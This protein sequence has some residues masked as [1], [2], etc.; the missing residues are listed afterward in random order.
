MNGLELDFYGATVRVVSDHAGVLESLR[1]DFE[2]FLAAGPAGG[3]SPVRLALSLGP[4]RAAGPTPSFLPTFRTREYAVYDKGKTRFIH[5]ADAALAVYDFAK[6]SGQIYCEDP[7]RLHELG[8]LA[9]LSRIGEELDLR[10]LH[11][12]HALGF[13]FAGRGGILLLPSGGGKSVLAL[14][15][16]RSTELGLLSDDTPLLSR[17]GRLAAFPLRLAFG[18]SEDLSDIPGRFIRPFRRRRYGLKRLA[19]GAFF[20]GRVRS[21]LPAAWLLI[22]ERREGSKPLIEP[23]GRLSAARALALN[24]VVGWGVAQMAEYL[25]RPSLDDIWSLSVIAASR[26]RS[27]WRLLTSVRPQRF[28]M[29]SDRAANAAALASFLRSQTG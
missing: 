17:E 15:L 12:V 8:Y 20:R 25:L 10:G 27:G 24:L 13:E 22:G 2:Y 21:G 16:L 9:I 3:A 23:C 4:P 29:G 14:E 11:R 26:W 18:P 19:D 28:V 5:Y 6:K 1:R 7:E